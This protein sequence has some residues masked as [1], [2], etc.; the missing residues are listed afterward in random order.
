MAIDAAQRR[1]DDIDE[2][3]APEEYFARLV[4]KEGAEAAGSRG[5]L[6]GA[7]PHLAGRVAFTRGFEE[8]GTGALREMTQDPHLSRLLETGKMDD[9]AQH[10][11]DRWGHLADD[12]FEEMKTTSFTRD[13]ATGE[14]IT[15]LL[16]TSPSPRDR[17]KSRMPSSA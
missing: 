9:A 5:P 6:Y 4:A 8:S 13:P 2:F 11:G 1:L 12:I 15:C 16:Y 14:V 3:I 10:L 17:Q 7:D